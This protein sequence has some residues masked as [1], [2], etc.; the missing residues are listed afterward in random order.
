MLEA[1]RFLVVPRRRGGPSAYRLSDPDTDEP[2]GVAADAGYPLRGLLWGLVGPLL[3]GR[4]LPGRLEVRE[5]PDGSLVFA[6]RR[7]WLPFANPVPVVDAVDR[8]VGWLVSDRAAGGLAVFD[9]DGRR[10]ADLTPKADGCRLS[11]TDGSELAQIHR[12]KTRDGDAGWLVE[13]ADELDGQPV[14][15]M[16]VQAAALTTDLFSPAARRPG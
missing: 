1:A 16:L 6:V 2:L 10:Y 15:K 7:G 12:S 8:P 11:A 3:A 14:T 9:A 13:T 5:P 4:V